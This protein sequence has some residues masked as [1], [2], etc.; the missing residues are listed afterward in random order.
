MTRLLGGVV[1]CGG[2]GKPLLSPSNNFDALVLPRLSPYTA[3]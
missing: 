3:T 1:A 2:A